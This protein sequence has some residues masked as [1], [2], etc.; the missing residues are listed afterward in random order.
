[1]K[2]FRIVETSCFVL[3]WSLYYCYSEIT[4][5]EGSDKIR[6]EAII[7][8]RRRVKVFGADH[9]GVKQLGADHRG[10]KQL[11]AEQNRVKNRR[12]LCEA[13]EESFAR[14]LTRSSLL[15]RFSCHFG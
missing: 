8:E 9:R 3:G 13:S 5:F 15:P 2:N 7:A 12:E 11:G 14:Q 10:V 1:M 4:V 6:I